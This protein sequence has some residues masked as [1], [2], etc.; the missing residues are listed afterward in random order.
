MSTP[1]KL[2]RWLPRLGLLA[3]LA[4]TFAARCYNYENVFHAD[5]R[6][7]FLEGD[8]YSRMTR[9]KMV[10]EGQWVIRHHDFENWPQGTTPHTTAPFDWLIA[11]LKGITDCGLRIADWKGEGHLRG[12]SLDHF[13][14]KHKTGVKFPHSL[15]V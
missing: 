11:G 8:C 2:P 13:I 5:G 7:Y 12:Q 9:V 4:L 15:K 1:S 6:I 14:K 10:C 3:L